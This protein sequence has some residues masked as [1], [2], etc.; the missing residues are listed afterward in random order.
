VAFTVVSAARV[1]EKMSV[2]GGR[3]R[4]SNALWE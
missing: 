3:S 2:Q 1:R 4:Y